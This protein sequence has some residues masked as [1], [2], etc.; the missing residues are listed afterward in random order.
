MQR[1]EILKAALELPEE[2]RGKLVDELSAS[3]SGPTLS[4]AWEREIAQRLRSL[5]AQEAASSP[6]DE[7]FDEAAA[8]VRAA[9]G[10]R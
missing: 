5:E 1:A 9:R 10:A 3:L 8:I 6:A 7:V 4:G 2:E